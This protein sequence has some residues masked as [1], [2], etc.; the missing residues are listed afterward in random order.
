MDRKRKVWRT[1]GIITLCLIIIA[2]GFALWVSNNYE[3]ILKKRIPVWIARNTDS[4]YK[5][6]IND[7]SINIFTHSATITGIKLWP[8]TNQVKKL[9]PYRRM[10]RSLYNITVPSLQA[11][12]IDWTELLTDKAISC[13][14]LLIQQP[15]L[16]ISAVSKLVDSLRYSLSDTLAY[17]KKEKK[18]A[19]KLFYAGLITITHPDVTYKLKDTGSTTMC[20]AHDGNIK[21]S[22]WKLEPD[23]PK[24]SKRFLYAKQAELNIGKVLCQEENGLYGFT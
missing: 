6:S 10:P 4:I 22:E 2:T 15:N 16:K 13:E 19:I 23:A 24:D 17:D 18:P 14:R 12:G 5:V 7:I 1:V 21:L 20:Y 3:R 9:K 8:D 11:S